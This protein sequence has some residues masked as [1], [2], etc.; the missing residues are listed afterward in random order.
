MSWFYKYS[1]SAL[2]KTIQGRFELGEPTIAKDAGYSYE[3]DLLLMEDL[4]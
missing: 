1:Q 2:D 4:N 3:Y